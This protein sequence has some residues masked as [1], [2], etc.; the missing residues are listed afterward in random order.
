MKTY[1]ELKT[2]QTFLERFSYLKIGGRIGQSTFGGDRWINQAF[3]TSK[4]WRRTRNGIIL[5]DNGCD[6][7]IDGHDIVR[8]LVIHH[9]NPVTIEDLEERRDCALDPDN[10]ICVSDITHK[11][12]HYGDE[13][14]LPK[15]FVERKPND[16]SP[17]KQ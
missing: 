9:I 16:T 4:E 13:S 14:L 8:N 11:A 7:G 1:K 17:W 12:I 6:L 15:P 3:Y 10:L 2:L 5:R